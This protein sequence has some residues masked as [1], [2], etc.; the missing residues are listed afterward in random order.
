MDNKLLNMLGLAKKAGKIIVGT[1]KITDTIRNNIPGSNSNL[2]LIASG[3]SE[4]TKKRVVN[5][6]DYYKSEYKII[7][8]TADELGH[9]IGRSN[10][11]S[12]VCV[13]DKNFTAVLKSFTNFKL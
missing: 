11:I 10:N 4:N 12:V 7:D 6:C 8:V 3:A 9:A 5:C 2:T 13:T 1:D